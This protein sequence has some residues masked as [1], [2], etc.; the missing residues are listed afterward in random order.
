MKHFRI[1]FLIALF[2]CNYQFANAE[3]YY[4]HPD[5]YEFEL[6]EDGTAK[7]TYSFCTNS[8]QTLPDEITANGK[9]YLVTEIGTFA[10]TQ[11]EF[12]ITL[13]LGENIQR[14]ETNAFFSCPYITTLKAGE[15]LKE[16]ESS[17]FYICSSLKNVYLNEKL[18]RLGPGAFSSC[19]TLTEITLPISLYDLKA[20]PFQNC[21]R[22]TEI[23]LS[24]ESEYLSIIDGMLL[25]KDKKYLYAVPQYINTPTLSIPEGVEIMVDN[26]ARSL[27]LVTA[28]ILPSSLKEIKNFAI[29]NNFFT[30]LEIPAN[31]E[32]IG[33]GNLVM[34][35]NLKD[36]TVNP[37]NQ[38]FMTD[39][40]LL[41]SKDGK[42]I[43]ASII[44]DGE[45]VIPEGVEEIEGYT[46]M[47]MQGITSLKCPDT[48]KK[49]GQSAFASAYSLADVQFGSSLEELG[50]ECFSGDI[51][52]TEVE[53]PS[54][55]KK[56]GNQ[57][58]TECDNLNG[59]YIP[60]GVEV[61]DSFAFFGCNKL[62]NVRIPGTVKEWGEYSFYLCPKME[63]L[64]IEEGVE[65]LGER[66][67]AFCDNLYDVTLPST[68]KSISLEA[69]IMTSI[70]NLEWP[71]NLETIGDYAFQ[72]CK[73]K[74]ITLPESV[75]SIG[76]NSFSWMNNLTTFSAGQNLESIG[77]NAFNRN[78]AMTDL[79][80]SA[81]TPPTVN[82]D[83]FTISEY[84]GYKNVTLHVPQ[85]SVDDYK[86]APV[87]Q[88][89]TSI[90][91]DISGISFID[92]S[93]NRNIKII[94]GVDGSI[95]NKITKGINIVVY[96]DGTTEK[97][98]L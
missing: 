52:I 63:T 34:C 87:W 24:G 73:F 10:Y 51:S 69:F 64:V 17:A 65:L 32:K 43:Y 30:S 62:K 84:N 23:K 5:G 38:F 46:F 90:S 94:Y 14:I 60:D 26:S 22:M 19:N 70:E 3:E 95:R 86:S 12:L 37:S 76:S 88:K 72:Y 82:T 2:F 7:L 18:E 1:I 67:F 36:L 45:I 48:L 40:K 39:G 59:I 49:I 92:D 21:Y 25:S 55:L 75:K 78:L 54:S 85:T 83:L 28:L 79:Y 68:L 42:K 58:F 16:I 15:N 50:R 93:Y 77:E 4:Y 9:E 35:E 20:N 57:A 56:I 71:E 27:G 6:H 91:G 74:E 41:M 13:T 33:A 81:L 97:V 96:D 53:L 66:A 47:Y 80:V 98:I 29:Q 8:E 89:F 31:V 61:I 11:D 44:Q